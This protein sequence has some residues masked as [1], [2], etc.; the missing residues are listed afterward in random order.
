M[1][2]VL[3]NEPKELIFCD[4]EKPEPQKGEVLIKVKRVGICGS[5]IH[6]YYGEHPTIYLPVVQ[7]HEFSGS[8]EAVGEGVEGFAIGEPVTVRPQYTC[9]ECF[10]CRSGHEISVTTWW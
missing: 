7:G 1:L 10:H 5:D 9:G 6:A 4:I 8:V 3:L 2:R